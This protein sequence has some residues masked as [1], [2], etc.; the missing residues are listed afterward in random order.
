[1][2]KTQGYEQISSAGDSGKSPMQEVVGRGQDCRVA[3]ALGKSHC[4][5]SVGGV[6]KLRKEMTTQVELPGMT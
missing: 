6:L 5:C 2:E 3:L 1:M 4:S